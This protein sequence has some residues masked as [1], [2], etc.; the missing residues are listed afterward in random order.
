MS[1]S[2]LQVGC[3]RQTT[4][5]DLKSKCLCH[6]PPQLHHDHRW[7]VELRRD[8]LACT[9]DQAQEFVITSADVPWLCG[10]VRMGHMD[11]RCASGGPIFP[12]AQNSDFCPR[13]PW[14][15]ETMEMETH[16]DSHRLQLLLAFG[17][18]RSGGRAEELDFPGPGGRIV[19]GGG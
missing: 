5:R 3:A 10:V 9:Q 6:V 15:P 11:A 16:G 7:F 17:S 1:L 19:R 4:L 13:K 18:T 8:V 14:K 12:P 2:L